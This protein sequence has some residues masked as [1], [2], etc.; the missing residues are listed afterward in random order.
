M[1]LVV[2]R[3]E[4][5]G[6]RPLG[7]PV[8]LVLKFPGPT[9]GVVSHQAFTDLSLPQQAC[10]TAG[11][12]PS[13]VVV[14]STR[15]DRSYDPIRHPAGSVRL[16]VWT[17]IRTGRSR[18]PHERGRRGLPQFPHPPSA[19]P[20]PPTPGQFLGACTSRSSAPSM[21]FAVISAAR[22]CLVP[23]TGVSLTRLQDSLH[24]AGW[25]V[26]PPKG[27]FDTALRRR[28]FPP[29]G[30]SLLPGLLAATRTGLT[31][32]GG[33]ELHVDHLT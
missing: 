20:A 12:L 10:D 6:R 16:P 4:T 13:P 25:T 27:A 14:L 33:H 28:A 31:P 23:L 19:H 1:D 22:H 8:K 30:G 26:A 7:R 29:D 21:A 32:A 18:T 24:A 15:L 9:T 2:E 3:V 5:P 17:V 11:V